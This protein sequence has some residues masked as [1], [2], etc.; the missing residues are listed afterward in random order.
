[1]Q[2]GYIDWSMSC[3]AAAA[4]ANGLAP[5][6]KIG[7]SVYIRAAAAV[8]GPEEWHH[9]SKKF[10]RTNFYRVAAVRHLAAQLRAVGDKTGDS[11]LAKRAA[12]CA[13]S[14]KLCRPSISTVLH[15]LNWARRYPDNSERA[16][17]FRRLAASELAAVR[18]Y[19]G[20]A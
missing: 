20:R 4:Y 7:S 12:R 16:R 3:R 9:T 17:E 15:Y 13:R 11:V 18:R 1:M 19:R 14:E 10:N 2:R 6:S 5:L 8:L